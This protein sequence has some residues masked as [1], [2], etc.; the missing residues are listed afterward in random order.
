M[1]PYFNGYVYQ[2]RTKKESGFRELVLKTNMKLQQNTTQM[3]DIMLHLTRI[4]L[5]NKEFR[6]LEISLLEFE[7]QLRRDQFS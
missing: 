2:G 6:T 4:T 7:G 1:L 5:K 3:T